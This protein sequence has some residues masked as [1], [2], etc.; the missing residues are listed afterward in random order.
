MLIRRIEKRDRLN[1]CKKERETGKQV[2]ECM[3]KIFGLGSYLPIFGI[4]SGT[5][6]N[7]FGVPTTDFGKI[8]PAVSAHNPIEFIIF[9]QLARINVLA[10]RS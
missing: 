3:T 5:V 1:G 7:V 8:L 4:F 6:E 2:W 9:R 10:D